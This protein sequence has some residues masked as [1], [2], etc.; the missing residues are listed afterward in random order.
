ML[1]AAVLSSCHRHTEGRVSS[2]SVVDPTVSK[3]L[4]SGFYASE[5]GFRW[6]GPLFTFVLP[7]PVHTSGDT[8]KAAQVTL[9]LYFPQ[10][11]IDQLGPVTITATGL[12]YQFAKAT[13]DKA[14]AYDF[15]VEIPPAAFSCTNL[16]PLTFSVDKYLHGANGDVRDLAVVVN[17]ISLRN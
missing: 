15:V 7:P 5:N 10:N 12:E 17:K 9:S 2:F 1:A 13:Y 8:A 16:L 11:E 3:Q 6:A 14:G 4:I